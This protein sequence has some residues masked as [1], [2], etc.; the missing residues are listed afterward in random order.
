[1]VTLLSPYIQSH[2]NNNNNGDDSDSEREQTVSVEAQ[3]ASNFA[4]YERALR[5]QQKANYLEA[6]QHYL[7][8]LHSPLLGDDPS[9]TSAMQLLKYSTL[10][11]LATIYESMDDKERALSYFVQAVDLDG[12]DLL[13]WFNIGRIASELSKWNVARVAFETA[14]RMSPSHWMSL[15]RLAELLFIIGDTSCCK[16][17]IQ[18]S[19]SIDSSN[20]RMLLLYTA[21]LRQEPQ[22]QDSS[23]GL[24]LDIDSR[25]ILDDPNARTYIQALM[26][27]REK[28]LSSQQI[29]ISNQD[30]STSSAGPSTSQYVLVTLSWDCLHSLL[31]SIY[32][33]KGTSTD[34]LDQYSFVNIVAVNPS[35]DIKMIDASEDKPEIDQQPDKEQEQSGT[36]QEQQDK[37]GA[38]P[39]DEEQ[40]DSAQDSAPLSGSSNS[41]SAAQSEIGSPS[42]NSL[43]SSSSSVPTP[44]TA[45]KRRERIR[46]G[47]AKEEKPESEKLDEY[48]DKLFKSYKVVSPVVMSNLTMDIDQQQSK[49]QQQGKGSNGKGSTTTTAVP[50]TMTTMTNNQQAM[51]SKFVNDTGVTNSSLTI[52]DWMITLLNHLTL[53]LSKCPVDGPLL[54]QLLATSD[55]IHKH[56]NQFQ[57][58]YL[59]LAEITFDRIMTVKDGSKDEQLMDKTKKMTTKSAKTVQVTEEDNEAKLCY[60]VQQLKYRCWQFREDTPYYIRYLWLVA[61]YAKHMGDINL[62]TCHFTECDEV[63][64]RWVATPESKSNNIII[65][66]NCTN[67]RFI[68]KSTLSERIEH[69][70]DQ[71]EKNKASQLFT[72]GEFDQ[73]INI[74]EPLFPDAFALI[75]VSSVLKMSIILLKELTPFVTNNDLIS[76]YYTIIQQAFSHDNM[77]P[78]LLNEPISTLSAILA[79]LV[80]RFYRKIVSYEWLRLF[81]DVYNVDLNSALTISNQVMLL[82]NLHG[83][84][85]KKKSCCGKDGKFLL[86]YFDLLFGFITSSDAELIPTDVGENRMDMAVLKLITDLSQCFY[87]LFG[88]KLT[89]LTGEED[90]INVRLNPCVVKSSSMVQSIGSRKDFKELI[91]KLYDQFPEPPERITKY[92]QAIDDYFAGKSDEV[93]D[94]AEVSSPPRAN[95]SQIFNRSETN[96]HG[97]LDLSDPLFDDIYTDIYYMF[98]TIQ[99]QENISFKEELLKKDLY[100]NPNRIATWDLLSRSFQTELTNATGEEGILVS[101]SDEVQVKIWTLYD[102]LR[103]IYRRISKLTPTDQIFRYLGLLLYERHCFVSKEFAKDKENLH[104]LFMESMS[105]FEQA[106][107]LS[108]T[109]S[110]FYPLYYAKISYKMGK[111][112]SEYLEMFDRAVTLLPTFTK[113][114]PPIEPIYRLHTCRLKLI[115]PYSSQHL[116]E[117]LITLLEKYNFQ[118]PATAAA[119][120]PTTSAITTSD[121]SNKNNDTS[122]GDDNPNSTTTTTTNTTTT[123]TVTSPLTLEKRRQLIID[124]AVVA[125]NY[126]K[127]LISF[128]HQSG[129]R[130]SW[131]IRQQSG[132]QKSCTSAL[133]LSEFVRLLKPKLSRLARGSVW[134]LWNE[135]YLGDGKLDRYFRKYYDFYIQLLEENNEFTNLDIIHSKTKLDIKFKEQAS[136]CYLACCNVLRYQFMQLMTASPTPAIVTGVDAQQDPRQ[137]ILQSQWDL[138]IDVSLYPEHR[139]HLLR[140]MKDSYL[141][142]NKTSVVDNSP[143]PDEAIVIEYFE[144]KYSGTQKR[145]KK[146]TT[147]AT[148]SA[149]LA[150]PTTGNINTAPASTSSTVETPSNVNDQSENKAVPSPRPSSS[151]ASNQDDKRKADSLSPPSTSQQSGQ[152]RDNKKLKTDTL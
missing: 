102:K 72:S 99:T 107:K 57:I 35:S 33:A 76:N 19:L 14:L 103:C 25:K 28:V 5:A 36:E 79:R 129:Y 143:S 1:M 74:L 65:L 30:T 38:Q 95:F 13:V 31:T 100:S 37:T 136:K 54:Q 128:H 110:W 10:K 84:L 39:M 140:L 26:K 77:K 62:A 24:P 50:E 92:R 85:A 75:D 20:S 40:S 46:G 29:D 64:S 148:A 87:C 117:D 70:Q 144:R 120:T 82:S 34:A 111:P 55:T 104:S 108:T 6:Q 89:I 61:R 113:K 12:G 44:A 88:I 7:N 134:S 71:Q 145:K 58:Y 96:D 149:S 124:N 11:N 86:H 69:L 17:I 78:S 49:Q 48:V 2:I 41:V 81:M 150:S 91:E 152:Q 115:L 106:E 15:E 147:T 80:Y 118:P 123:T 94:V 126:C 23:N 90:E 67:D 137:K 43:N 116:D 109:D 52:V 21:L 122:M 141:M 59:M 4:T 73:V 114:N 51:V 93:R 121:D 119:G 32:N 139:A 112:P 146:S 18:R 45:P 131:A 3:E 9:I 68:S 22:Q 83:E 132:H 42:A 97:N 27:R 60:L 135:G 138:Y 130:I 151:S 133:A 63:F 8:L 101:T 98:A 56:T 125:L 16:Q 47:V 142:M 105:Y 53:N 66:H 127:T